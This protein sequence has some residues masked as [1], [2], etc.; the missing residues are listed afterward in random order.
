MARCI[1]TV[2]LQGILEDNNKIINY[3]QSIIDYFV[4][5]FLENYLYK[6]KNIAVDTTDNKTM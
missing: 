4:L 5:K 6:P 2:H 3:G 1:R